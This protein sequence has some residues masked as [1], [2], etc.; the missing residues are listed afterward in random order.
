MTTSTPSTPRD[1]MNMMLIWC[2]NRKKERE[3]TGFYSDACIVHMAPDMCKDLGLESKLAN[4]FTIGSRL[5]RG[6]RG[7]EFDVLYTKGI[8]S[9]GNGDFSLGVKE[10]ISELFS[11]YSFKYHQ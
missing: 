1:M 2:E 5:F 11:F 4:C 10:S 8:E 6:G 9:P 7:C 3:H